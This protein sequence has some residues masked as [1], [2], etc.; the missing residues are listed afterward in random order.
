[1][2]AEKDHRMNDQES[3]TQGEDS[4]L[5]SLKRPRP[6]SSEIASSVGPSFHVKLGEQSK[7]SGTRGS[8]GMM[9]ALTVLI[10]AI[11]YLVFVFSRPGA[12]PDVA[13]LPGLDNE[14]ADVIQ[15]AFALAERESREANLV[16]AKNPSISESSLQTKLDYLVADSLPMAQLDLGHHLDPIESLLAYHQFGDS[17]RYLL[18]LE[19]RFTDA[20]GALSGQIQV[21]LKEWLA[22]G[23]SPTVHDQE[24]IAIL[25]ERGYEKKVEGLV[26]R[27]AEEMPND[28][29]WMRAAAERGHLDSMLRLA[30]RLENELSRSTSAEKWYRKAAEAGSLEAIEW[31]QKK[32]ITLPPGS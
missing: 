6:R 32:G 9:L 1:M 25:A 24:I 12:G 28:A 18:G 20:T 13:S 26:F 4:G 27:G 31:F 14:P 11:C 15:P 7:D 29:V 2:A 17:I 19:R 3:G 5:R 8:I 23:E 10:A 30:S 22:S 21:I 16:A